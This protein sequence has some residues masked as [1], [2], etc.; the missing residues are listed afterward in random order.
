[1]LSPVVFSS[2]RMDWPTP[3]YI[4]D[5]LN[6]RYQFTCDVAADIENTKCIKFYDQDQDGLSKDW[7]QDRNWMNPP[8]GRAIS[9]W[10]KKAAQTIYEPGCFTVG[11]LPARTDTAWFHDHIHGKAKSVTFLRGRIKFEG[12]KN[13]APFPSMIVIWGDV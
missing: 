7:S 2:I 12:A 6:A 13:G 5:P 9:H 10:V 4:Y 1:M 8:Y 11:L 3:G